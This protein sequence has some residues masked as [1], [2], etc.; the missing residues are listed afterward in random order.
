MSISLIGARCSQIESRQIA[1]FRC[2]QNRCAGCR[3]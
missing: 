3:E 2:R 1:S